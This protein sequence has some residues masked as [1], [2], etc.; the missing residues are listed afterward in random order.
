[1]RDQQRLIQ[2][3]KLTTLGILAADVAHDI[4]N[5]NQTILSDAELLNQTWIQIHPVLEQY[6]KQTD[7]FLVAGKQQEELI[8]SVARW[9]S[10][11]T[12]NS[13]R[14]DEIVKGLKSYIRNEPLLMRSVNLNTIVRSSVE[15]MANHLK[16]ATENF[17]LQLG[18][19]LPPIRGNAQRLEQV[20]VNLLLN[21]CQS[22][23]DRKKAIG[24]YTSHDAKKQA[25][26]LSV[27]DEGCGIPE[28][29]LDEIKNPFFTTKFETYGIGL[30]LHIADTI[31]KEHR[32]SLDFLSKIGRG[33]EAVASFP[34][35]SNR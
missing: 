35:E 32:G 1:M 25:V 33:T 12:A 26:C 19:N 4:S 29:H 7:Q 8:G 3:D 9:L 24:V 10:T 16:R 30:G 34:A 21:S 22:L 17:T 2:T 15:L 27:R 20:V 13:K 23:A 5:P 31:V 11:I 6:F 14:I 28:E 18:E